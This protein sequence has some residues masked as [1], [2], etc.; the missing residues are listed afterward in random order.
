[1]KSSKTFLFIW[2]FTQIHLLSFAPVECNL[3]YTNHWL[4]KLVFASLDTIL[5]TSFQKPCQYS[6]I[7]SYGNDE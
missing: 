1:M 4:I 7:T 6:L 2:F 5:S 3:A